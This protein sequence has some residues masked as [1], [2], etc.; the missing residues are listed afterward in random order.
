M[1]RILTVLAALM[2]YI[3][4]TAQ[5]S[6]VAAAFTG[7]ADG[8]RVVVCEPRNGNL[9]PVDTLAPDSK[10]CVRVDRDSKAPVF[11][12]LSLTRPQSPLV[13]VM[14]LPGERVSLK[15]EYLPD[16]N[17]LRLTE[18]KGSKNMEL[19]RD[20][21]Q[22]MADAMLNPDK[23]AALPYQMARLLDEHPD[24][25]MSA[26]LVT[27]F[28][29]TFEQYAPL[30]KKIRDTLITTY[31]SNGF[32]RYLDNKL[33]GA[34]VAG[35][36]A[37]DIALP[38]PEGRERRLSDLRGKV[39]LVDFWASWCRPCRMEN[40]NVVRLYRRYKDRGFEVFSVSLDNDRDAWLRAIKH[41][42]LLWPNH[43][44]DLRGWSSEGGKLYGVSSIPTTVLVGP[45]GTILA[46]NLRGEELEQKLQSIF[47]Q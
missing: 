12:S 6:S 26:F 27:Y 28:E 33:R 10:G 3:A 42:G 30:Y 1:K 34:I 38:D 5:K 14:L 20:Y 15:V 37:P 44:S 41:D 9:V 13:H 36:E 18:S 29:T 43:V 24:R 31:P 16:V 17:F 22:L 11:V 40:P 25:L 21:T 8:E 4:A 47:G 2:A 19:Y 39:V 45:D 46:R 32:V 7:I 23:Q 35:V